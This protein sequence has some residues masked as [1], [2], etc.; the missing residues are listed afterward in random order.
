[1]TGIFQPHIAG[2]DK[3]LLNVPVVTLLL[4]NTMVI[5]KIIGL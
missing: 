4:L 2:L 5:D 1:M 3:P